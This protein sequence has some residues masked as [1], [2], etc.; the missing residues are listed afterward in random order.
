MKWHEKRTLA[1]MQ[2]RA[3]I[4]C[5]VVVSRCSMILGQNDI[6]PEAAV[7]LNRLPGQISAT[8]RYPAKRCV[9]TC[10]IFTS[11]SICLFSFQSPYRISF[12]IKYGRSRSPLGAL[13]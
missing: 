6:E 11:K 4:E 3:R 2:D 5:W 12:Q 1:E 13:T 8:T 7:M 10:G 9:R